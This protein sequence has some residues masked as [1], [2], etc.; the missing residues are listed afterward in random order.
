MLL[1]SNV[2]VKTE[3]EFCILFCTIRKC[4]GNVHCTLWTDFQDC[5]DKKF[6]PLLILHINFG[7]VKNKP[8]LLTQA[9]A[10]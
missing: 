9:H 10:K 3:E 7:L 1:K 2:L 4:A 5:L 6:S 8:S